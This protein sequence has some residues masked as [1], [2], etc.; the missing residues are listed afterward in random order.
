MNRLGQASLSGDSVLWMELADGLGWSR[1]NF[2][3]MVHQES[4]YA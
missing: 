3:G 4:L 1:F 2:P